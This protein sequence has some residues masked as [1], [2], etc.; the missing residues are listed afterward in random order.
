MKNLIFSVMALAAFSV[1]SAQGGTRD[2]EKE[3]GAEC[4]KVLAEWNSYMASE[5]SRIDNK[6]NPLPV[7][8]R[9]KCALEASRENSLKN[10]ALEEARKKA[11]S[12][13]KK[14]IKKFK[15]EIPQ[16]DNG[17]SKDLPK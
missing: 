12:C 6:C 2:C 15:G 7:D 4:A 3:R 11:C 16:E 5:S 13:R 9:A 1:P 14:P 8:E 17:E 10:S